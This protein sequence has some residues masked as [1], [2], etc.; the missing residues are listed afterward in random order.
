MPLPARLLGVGGLL[1]FA[2]LCLAAALDAPRRGFWVHAQIAYG[3]VILSFVGALH[4]AFAMLLPE[5]S[6]ARSWGMFGWSVVPGL[7]AWVALLVPAGAALVLLIGLF[8]L[9]FRVDMLLAQRHGL[10]GWYLQLRL[11]LTAGAVFALL[12]TLF[13]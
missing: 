4:W 7:V 12:L 10:P 6:P 11:T 8:A 13:S 1:P 9:H 2:F 5:V 3:A